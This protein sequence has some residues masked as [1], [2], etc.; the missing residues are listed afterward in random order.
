MHISLA[1]VVQILPSGWDPQFLVLGYI[2]PNVA[3]PLASFLAAFLGVILLFGRQ[4]VGLVRKAYKAV[5]AR[6]TGTPA[7]EPPST[8][9]RQDSDR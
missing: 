7:A 3:I 5:R 4:L 6:I 8:D 2:G 1:T 9:L